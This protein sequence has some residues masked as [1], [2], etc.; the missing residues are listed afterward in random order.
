MSIGVRNKV[1]P[2]NYV[3]AGFLLAVVIGGILGILFFI[4]GVIV[5]ILH[6]PPPP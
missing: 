5:R 4:S 1:L 2:D 6:G 3:T